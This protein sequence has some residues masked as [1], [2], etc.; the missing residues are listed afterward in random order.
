M[1]YGNKP[2]QKIRELREVPLYVPV[3]RV[4]GTRFRFCLHLA[5]RYHAA[6]RQTCAASSCPKFLF[7]P[8]DDVPDSLPEP[9]EFVSDPSQVIHFDILENYL[10]G[11]VRFESRV[12]WYVSVGGARSKPEIFIMAVEKV[13]RLNDLVVCNPTGRFRNYLEIN[14]VNSNGN[15]PQSS[16]SIKPGEIVNRLESIPKPAIRVALRFFSRV[17]LYRLNPIPQ[18]AG[19]WKFVESALLEISIPSIHDRELQTVCIGGRLGSLSKGDCIPNQTIESRTKLISVL[20]EF[21]RQGGLFGGTERSARRNACDEPPAVMVISSD[22]GKA[23]FSKGSPFFCDNAGMVYRS[24]Q[25]S[26]AIFEPR[27]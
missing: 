26:P 21:E 27:L 1:R 8:N 3:G 22:G 16:V 18:L 12:C 23:T 6:E 15:E 25:P 19:E 20:A 24:I 2:P 4:W 13:K 14:C 10:Q 11:N 9:L 17:R 5:A 7:E